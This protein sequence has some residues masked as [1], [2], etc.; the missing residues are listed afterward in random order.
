MESLRDLVR[1]EKSQIKSA[2]E[3]LAR[4]FYDDPLYAYLLPDE[5][6]RKNR[7]Y[8][9]HQFC[10]RYGLFYG[11]V[12]TT[13][14][15][16]EGVAVWLPPGKT[17]ITRWGEIRSGGLS[18][19]F[20]LGMKFLSRQGSFIRCIAPMH[21]RHA[22]FPHWYLFHLGVA[23]IHQGKGYGGTL[24]TAMLARM[25]REHLPCYLETQQENNVA[26]YQRYGF[27]VVE[28]ADIPGA[29]FCDWAMLREARG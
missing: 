8:Y 13:S 21:Q 29:G 22:P 9:L 20:K 27:R 25:D 17:R 18:I 3:M 10:L 11:E 4:A 14:P 15:N 5:S 12:Y 19:L 28:R 6:E 23:P 26:I 7:S 24:L 2:A 1:L 16:L